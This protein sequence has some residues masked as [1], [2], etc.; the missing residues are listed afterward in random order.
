MQFDPLNDA[1]IKMY[2]AEQ[3]GKFNVEL[4]PASKLLGNV[5]EIMQKSGY[6]GSIDRTEN[7]RGGTYLVELRLSLIHI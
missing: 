1:L 4:A 6:V 2:N 7:G 5:L 3:A